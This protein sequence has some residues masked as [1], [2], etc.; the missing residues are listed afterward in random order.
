MSFYSSCHWFILG[1]ISKNLFPYP[2]Q[3]F[4][5]CSLERLWLL[6]CF[7]S[8]LFFN[9]LSS[10]CLISSATAVWDWLF[11]KYLREKNGE[12]CHWECTCGNDRICNMFFFQMKSSFKVT[13]TYHN[14]VY[15]CISFLSP[16]LC[17]SLLNRLGPLFLLLYILLGTGI[18]ILL[19]SGAWVLALSIWPLVKGS[20]CR[21]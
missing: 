2:T 19:Y 8:F 7:L 21:F 11:V 14:S 12:M 10:T 4:S 16:H 13:I 9:W 18:L 5:S 17:P 1:G 3:C 15:V 6:I 20:L